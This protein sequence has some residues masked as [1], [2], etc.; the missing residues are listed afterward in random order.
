MSTLIIGSAFGGGVPQ[1]KSSYQ[2]NQLGEIT[3]TVEYRALWANWI[4][5]APSLGSP[6]PDTDTCCLTGRDAKQILPGFLCDVT[7]TYSTPAGTAITPPTIGGSNPA[8]S[9]PPDDYTETANEVEMPIEAH[10]SFATIATKANGAIWKQTDPENN[11]DLWKFTGWA[12]DSPY[13]GFLTF[14]VGSISESITTYSWSKPSTVTALIGTR[15][16][17][18][19]TIGGSISRRGAY[20][21]RTINRL[22]S[23]IEWNSV[24]YP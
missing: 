3:I 13:A 8:N 11:P 12:K 20:W 10:P 17:H 14:K 22:Y 21:S 23:T 24:I 16:G 18:W 7:L 9:L 6:H 4:T 15:S 1:A 19:L 2:Q 5:T